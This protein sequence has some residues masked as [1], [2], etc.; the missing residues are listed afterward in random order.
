MHIYETIQKDYLDAFKTK[1]I[2]RKDILGYMFA[3]LKSKKIDLQKDLTDEEVIQMIKKEIKTRHE[4]ITYA[5]NAWKSEDV[6]LDTEKIRVL[7]T[8]LPRQFTA[9][10]L[11]S[12]IKTTIHDLWITDV[13]KQRGQL[14]WALMKSYSTQIDGKLLNDC[15]SSLI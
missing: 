4:S 14:I 7:E 3:Q 13:S 15:I 10:E 8:F 12:L 6:A 9:E 11:L 5:T 2:L 1:D